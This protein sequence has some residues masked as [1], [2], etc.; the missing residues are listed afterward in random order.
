MRHR[1]THRIHQ[2]ALDAEISMPKVHIHHHPAHLIKDEARRLG[3]DAVGIA[4]A[5]ALSGLVLDEWLDRGYHGQMTY[6]ARNRETRLDPRILV[7]GARSVISVAVN[8]YHPDPGPNRPKQAR[9]SRYAWG[10]DYHNIVKTRL[11]GLLDF[12]QA[13]FPG[14]TGRVFV[15][16]API[17]DKMWAV[18]AGIGW[19]GKHGNVITPEHGSW[20]F[21]GEVV[22][23]LELPPDSPLPDY[24]GT[25]T[26]CINACPTGAIVAPHLVDA[27][28]CISYLTIELKPEQN[29]PRSLA[30]KMGNR[31]FGCDTCQ[32]VCPWNQKRQ[33]TTPV[34]NFHPRPSLL[35]LSLD[36]IASLTPTTFSKLFKN[37]PVKRTK[38]SGLVRNYRAIEHAKSSPSGSNN[39]T[40]E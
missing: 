29:I 3:F 36:T 1:S 2:Q 17:M 11:F 32:D 14:T 12:I 4:Q 18:K 8:Y 5:E 23:S 10:S 40:R 16:T 33:H 28:R 6:M 24:C 27:R 39:D 20:V 31:I 37:S 19:L 7:P 13:E 26:R 15:D 35:P 21:L 25:C 22:V 30:D 9:V 38:L 34:Q